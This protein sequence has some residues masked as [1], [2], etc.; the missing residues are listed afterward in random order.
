MNN[1]GQLI[2]QADAII[3]SGE[4]VL[5]TKRADKAKIS[6]VDEQ[7]FHDFRISALSYLGRVFGENSAYCKNFRAEV[8]QPSASRTRRG[9]GMMTAAQREL[10]GNWLETTRGS[11]SRDILTDMLRLAYQHLKQDNL[12]PAVSIAG[13]VLDK[14]LRDLCMARNISLHNRIQG[15]AVTKNG[16]QLTG[17]AYKK[18]L[19]DRRTNKK[20]IAWFELYKNITENKEIKPTVDL[21]KDMLKGVQSFITKFYHW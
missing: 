16:L 4:K 20:I 3:Q 11:I 12:I 9:I 7:K 21:A 10:E 17:E 18:K 14:S 15:R 5:A 1:Q 19:F 13:A 6:T 8:T 2:A